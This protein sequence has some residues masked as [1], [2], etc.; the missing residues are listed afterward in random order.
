MSIIKNEEISNFNRSSFIKNLSQ[1]YNISTEEILE[2]LLDADICYKKIKK[3]IK[4]PEKSYHVIKK[5]IGPI[6]TKYGKFHQILFEINDAWKDYLVIVKARIDPGSMLPVFDKTKEIYLRIDSGCSSGQLFGDMTCECR[7]Q[8]DLSMN[9]LSKKPQGLIIHIPYQDG[10]GKGTDFK[11]A[12]LYIQER[13]GLDTIESF[14]LLERDNSNK[15]LDS[16][17]YDGVVS[18]LKFFN[19]TRNI[20]LGTNSP[21]KFK[22]I[23]KRGILIKSGEPV[24]IIPTKL[25]KMHLEAKK[26]ILGHHFRG[27]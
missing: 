3:E 14:S 27:N 1:K 7:D 22:E 17:D 12:T 16:R 13:L 6:I 4:F 15:G 26:K 18:I 25:T 20:V 2:T 21:H 24:S 5:G 11:L 19:I 8:L 10:R 9:I 23:Q